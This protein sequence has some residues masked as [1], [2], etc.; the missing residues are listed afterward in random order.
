M[1]GAPGPAP[2]QLDVPAL[3][4]NVESLSGD[5]RRT[6][7]LSATTLAVLVAVASVITQKRPYMIT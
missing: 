6:R 2:S 4:P 5:T 7:T 1:T 3:I